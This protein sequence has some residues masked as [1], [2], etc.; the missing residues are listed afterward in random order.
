MV[1]QMV[2]S[3]WSA[4][5]PQGPDYEPIGSQDV[6]DTEVG[7]SDVGIS[8]WNSSSFIIQICCMGDGNGVIPGIYEYINLY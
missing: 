6:Y 3:D 4:N 5:G 7:I 8:V 2:C 1:T